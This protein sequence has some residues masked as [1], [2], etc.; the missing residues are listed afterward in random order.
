MKDR[1]M[2]FKTLKIVEWLF[3][4]ILPVVLALTIIFE[5]WYLPLIFIFVAVVTFGILIS[6]LK[7]V[8]EDEMTRAIAEKG[9]NGA[10]N[11]G[12]IL[13]LLAGTILLAISGD[14]TSSMGIAAITLFSASFGISTINLF[15]KL[16]YKNKLGVK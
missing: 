15:T 16:Y 1:E 11:I 10:I 4:G 14:N 5:L 7:E 13:M 9:A 3:C 6:H 8:Y 12:C 2:K